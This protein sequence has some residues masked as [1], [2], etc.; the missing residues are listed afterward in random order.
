MQAGSGSVGAGK[1]QSLRGQAVDWMFRLEA[2][3]G[4]PEVRAAFDAWLATSERHRR[5]YDTVREVWQAAESLPQDAAAPAATG[6]PAPAPSSA[7]SSPSSLPPSSFSP[8]SSLPSSSPS[9]LPSSPG[10]ATGTGAAA[11]PERRPEDRRVAGRPPTWRAP[12]SGTR[13]SRSASLA[14][15]G[16]ARRWGA[17][18]AASVAACLVLLALPAIQLRLA[19]DHSTGVAERRELVLDDGSRVGLD[20]GSA[21]ALDYS[22]AQRG[23]TLLAGQA[24]FDVAPMPGR[25]FVV[26]AGDV[27]VTVTGTSFDVDRSG[28]SVAVAVRT[29]RVAVGRVAGDRDGTQLGTLT[30]GQTLRVEAGDVSRGSIDPADVASWQ[31]GRL[32]VHEAT[33]RDVVGQIGRYLPGVIVFGDGAFAA[34]KVTGVIDLQ[35]PDEALQAVVGLKQGR[36]VRLS[37]YLTLVLAR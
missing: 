19:A 22:A 27:R 20:A 32:V 36:L 26:T 6:G 31:S 2:G 17:A 18:V 3:A 14:K 29:G 28:A 16:R 15:A 1:G 25:P 8:P 5:A 24:F 11:R 21:I 7:L 33:V 34:R 10:A 37:P 4:D 9:P 23:V 12:T 30:A 13:A 35:R